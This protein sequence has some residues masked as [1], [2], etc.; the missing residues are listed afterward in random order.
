MANFFADNFSECAAL[1]VFL[2]AMCPMVESKIAI[3]FAL[4]SVLWGDSTLSPLCAFFVAFAGSMLP[5]ILIILLSRFVKNKTSGFVHDKFTSFM[6]KHFQKNVEKV[7]SKSSTL[8]KCMALATFVAV[9]LPLTGTYAG[10]LVSGFTNLK[11]WQCFLSVLVGEL[12][13][14]GV[15]LALC[16]LFENSAFYV[17]LASICLLVAFLLANFIVTLISKI[18]KKRDVNSSFKD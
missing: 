11:I 15:M 10:S 14:C 6:A 9:P 4:S 8:K 7:S 12:L 1:A 5:S 2:L 17:L 16:L 13:S 3:P 18:K